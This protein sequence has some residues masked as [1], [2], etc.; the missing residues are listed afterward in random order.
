MAKESRLQSEVIKYLKHKGC[1]VIKN[2]PGAGTPVGCPDIIA[3][4]EGAWLAL[5]IKSDIE[6]PY[7]PLQKATIDKLSDW[8]LCKMICP[9]NW[10]DIKQ[11]LERFIG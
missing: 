8:S 7:Q 4:I 5:E 1:Y 9:Q 3:L 10:S 2:T 11:E 6:S